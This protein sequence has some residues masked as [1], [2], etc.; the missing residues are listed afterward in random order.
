MAAP[1]LSNT[2]NPGIGRFGVKKRK[3]KSTSPKYIDVTYVKCDSLDF[4]A[5]TAKNALTRR[6][7][8]NEERELYILTDIKQTFGLAVNDPITFFHKVIIKLI[9]NIA[10]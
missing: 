6:I 1:L 4:K 3:V 8:L 10:N 9:R 2:P 5:L 7:E